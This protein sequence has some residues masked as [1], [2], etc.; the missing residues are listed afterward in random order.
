M[1]ITLQINIPDEQ[2]TRLRDALREHY[3]DQTLTAEQ[4]DSRLETET[5][6]RLVEI[7][8]GVERHQAARAAVDTVTGLD[9]T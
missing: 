2:A 9:L 6:E 4:V 8:Q 5:K 1:V 7:V 3:Q